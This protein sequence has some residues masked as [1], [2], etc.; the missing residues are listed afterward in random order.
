M[1][2]TVKRYTIVDASDPD[3]PHFWIE[4]FHHGYTWGNKAVFNTRFTDELSEA[5]LLNTRKEAN[6]VL[7][8]FSDYEFVQTGRVKVNGQALAI[9]TIHVTFEMGL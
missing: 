3:A 1:Q 5:T 6:E 7:Q 2:R 9:R 4:N 8:R